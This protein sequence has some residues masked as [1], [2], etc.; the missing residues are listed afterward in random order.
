MP[1][2]KDTLYDSPQ[3]IVDFRFD[4]RTVA[5]FPDMIHRSIPG[6]A[7]LLQMT[8]AVASDFIQENSHIYDLGCSLG[9]VS[10]ALSQKLPQGAHISAIDQ[11]SAMIARLQAYLQ[12][13]NLTHI[14]A[15]EA[16]ITVM[17]FQPADLIIL[18]FVLQFIPPE[19]RDT[20]LKKIYHS[21]HK[22]S[23]LL[24][25]E[26]IQPDDARI[27]HWHETFKRHQGYSDMA[28]AQKRE[29]LE[30]VMKTDTYQT[31]YNRLTQA[32]FSHIIPYFQGLSFIAIAAIKS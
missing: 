1:Y 12:G 19:Q 32:G 21:L 13:A 27:T 6:Y 11:S 2:Q 22:N 23:A 9:G 15:E 14:T 24:I 10:L 18:N 20:L 5:V 8:S 30:N 3:A 7:A 26:K 16:D 4:E 29:S 17:D 25:A 28:I 31:L